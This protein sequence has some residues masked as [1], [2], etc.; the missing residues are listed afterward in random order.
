MDN[1]TLQIMDDTLMRRR[2]IFTLL[3]IMTG[4]QAAMAQTTADTLRIQ[5]PISRADTYPVEIKQEGNTLIMSAHIPACTLQ[6][7]D[8]NEHIFYEAEIPEGTKQWKFLLMKADGQAAMARSVTG[9]VVDAQGKAL[10]YVN[11]VLRNTAD[12]TYITS[13]ITDRN[14][15]FTLQS[16]VRDC[17]LSLKMLGFKGKEMECQAGDLGTIMLQKE[18]ADDEA[19]HVMPP[20]VMNTDTMTYHVGHKPLK[21]KGKP[22]LTIKD[23]TLVYDI[24]QI[25]FGRTFANAKEMVMALP[26][27]VSPDGKRMKVVGAK[28]TTLIISGTF[29]YEGTDK[30]G[31]RK[32][33]LELTPAKKVKKV[34]VRYGDEPTEDWPFKG[35]TLNVIL[36]R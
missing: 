29:T 17:T 18:T 28:I 13:A 19:G 23:S 14:G 6:L 34:I 21:G 24:A 3:I 22:A 10:Q 5:V 15:T 9:K 27:V 2:I 7:V 31:E 1:G 8:K 30:N 11:C 36:S 33:V 26:S 25:P 16:D 12:S 4:W 32:E 20:V 35:T